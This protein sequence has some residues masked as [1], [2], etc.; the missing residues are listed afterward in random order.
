VSWTLAF[1]EVGAGDVAIVGGK[2]A[3]LGELTRAGLPVPAGFCVTAAAY[4]AFISESGTWQRIEGLLHDLPD[5]P[6]AVDEIATAIRAL[7]MEQPMPSDVAE[8]IVVRYR[9]LAGGPGSGKEEGEADPPVAVRSSAT[10]EDL[11]DASFAG[12]QDT[13]LNVRGEEQVL[14]HVRQCWASLW[15]A[16]AVAY[17]VKQGYDH[18]DVALAVAVQ[19]MVGADVAGVLFTADPVTSALVSHVINAS[20]GLGEAIVSGL[21]TP[22]TWTIDKSTGAVTDR[23]IGRKERQVVRS[24]DGGTDE[25]DVPED[26][27]DIASLTDDQLAELARFGTQIEEHYGR[28]MDVEWAYADGRCFILQARPITT[29]APSPT[30]AGPATGDFNRT[31]FLE[32]FPDPLSPAFISVVEPLFGGMLD[33]TFQTLGFRT[34]TGLPPVSAFYSQ[35]YLNQRYIEAALAPLKPK[36]R[37]AF[38]GQIVNPFGRHERGAPVEVS[39][40]FARMGWRLLRLMRS[41]HELL[42]REV[43]RYQAAISELDGLDLDELSERQLV[44]RVDRLVFGAAN[45]LLNYDFLL[46]ALVGVTYQTLGSL[47]E[48]YFGDESEDIRAR[49]VSGVTGN[50]TM[51]TNKR[52][53]ELSRA[54]LVSDVVSGQL[55]GA[56]GAGGGELLAR[57]ADSA[58]GRSF[59]GELDSFLA[60]YGHREIRMDILY[61]TWVE[62][63]APVLSFVRGYLDVP[64]ESSPHHQ[65][66]RLVREREELAATVRSRVRGDLRGRLIV[67]PIFRWVLGHTQAN[68]RQRDT[69][70]FELT[71]L[72]PPFRRLLLE[73]GERFAARGIVADQ[74]DIFYLTLDEMRATAESAEAAV[75]LQP[76]VDK[77][78]HELEAN[79]R[80]QPP[81]IVRDGRELWDE[82]VAAGAG[83]PVA[84]EL[85]GIAGSPGVV[86]GVV[87][88]VRGPDEFDKLTEGEILVAPLTNPVWTP[89]FAIA[90]GLVTE[91][92]GIL[93][94][95]A[96]VAREYGIPAVMAVSGA[97]STLRDGQFVTV[98]GSRGTVRFVDDEADP[99]ADLSG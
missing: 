78:R 50:V 7:L 68:T 27:R 37:R 64:E 41:L 59:V 32:I 66:E 94:H 65:Q 44:E 84:G 67:W 83:E 90:G 55:R 95:G 35:P 81:S 53:W 85:R 21:V 63:P 29:L 26:L 80:R 23:R 97:I 31:M 38:V 10:A 15:T 4:R 88:I 11:P 46:I 36:T 56:G 30:A 93:S 87:R 71:R 76:L 69:M 12:Q 5:D 79:R 45:R 61:P 40:P 47:L 18:A 1:G 89:L 39:L 49:L 62:D 96:I 3:N 75:S 98:D 51:E 17:R 13:Y 86:S 2:A 77:R 60:E 16:R 70:H 34:P 28:P 74:A 42:P 58:E 92:G 54:A 72:F 91:V 22:D 33:F 8:Q 14:D 52:L 43:A 48:R 73:L 9:Q 82:G 20:W 99:A 6:A 19:R 57:L 24:A 25:H